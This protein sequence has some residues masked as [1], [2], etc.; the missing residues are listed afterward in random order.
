MARSFLPG[1][2]IL[3]IGMPVL[4]GYDAARS[5]R[6]EGVPGRPLVLVALTSYA[7]PSDVD[8][9]RQP[10]FDHH[11]PK[12]V[13]SDVLLALVEALVATDKLADGSAPSRIA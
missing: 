2:A 4:N 5:I 1:L 7:S 13:G 11:L 6:S 10:G 3:D 8:F 12:G 9:A